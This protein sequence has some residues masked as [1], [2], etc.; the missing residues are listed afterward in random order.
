MTVPGNG[1]AMPE[2]EGVT[3]KWIDVRGTRLHVAEA[4]SGEPLILLH[5]F[6]QNWWE[7]H[8]VI[9]LMAKQYRIIAPDQRGFGWSDAARNGYTAGSL[10][11]DIVELMVKLGITRA[12]FLTH[13]WGA[14][15][16]Q[17]LAMQRP[18]L[19]AALVI[20]GAPDVHIKPDARLVPV[21]PK[22]WHAFALA[23]PV[24]GPRIQRNKKMM[25]HLFTAFEPPGGL[26]DE[27]M[28][29]YKAS[30]A[31]PEAARAGSA[32]YRGTILPAFMKIVLGAYA[33]NDFTVPTLALIGANEPSSTLQG[34]GH[35]RG[36]GGNVT[37]EIIQGEG[38]FL[39]DHRPE[40]VARKTLE[41]FAR[42]GGPEP[43]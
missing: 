30:A 26:S 7:W 22:L 25:R 11:A 17:L 27:D 5:G 39:I 28:E 3:H 33:K 6:P 1:A 23:A 35:H 37:T 24:I 34:M 9:P 20:S 18:D 8:D 21:F 2:L 38:H 4:G 43:A 41:F 10:V 13:D 29:L 31:R 12:R 32:L 15:V 36:R 42:A 14:I 16:G 19:V 40:F